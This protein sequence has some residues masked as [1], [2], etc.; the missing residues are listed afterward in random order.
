MGYE[1]IT[2][3][4]HWLKSQ[5]KC[6]HNTTIKYLIN[7]KKV[8][9]IEVKN[10]WLAKDPFTGFKMSRAN[11]N[12][13]A[14]TDSELAK[15]VEKDF[16]NTRLNQVRDI[17]VFCCYTGLA[18]S[19]VNKLNRKDIIDGYAG[20]KWLVINR[21]KTDSQSRVPLLPPALQIRENYQHHPLS[22]VKDQLL[23]VL[24][25]QKINSYLKEIGDVCRID[26]PITFHLARH[27]FATTVTLTNGVPIES[28]SK[29]LVN[30]SL[31][32]TQIYAKI[33]DRKISEDMNLLKGKLSSAAQKP[34]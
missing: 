12:R 17:F 19:D 10:G 32:T 8:V 4:E 27:T 3:F 22:V 24:S 33:V 29:M 5:K 26:K 25:N 7:L 34:N 9:L 18:Y 31:K 23:P 20:E 1:F 6:A 2:D 15:I 11:V 28:V 13:H 16:E 30:S 14:L 21:Q